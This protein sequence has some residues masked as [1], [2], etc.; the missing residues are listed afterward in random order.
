[1]REKKKRNAA[2]LTKWEKGNG[3]RIELRLILF[4]RVFMKAEFTHT[5]GKTHEPTKV[6][7]VNYSW[8]FS[9][10]LLNYDPI[11]YWEYIFTATFWESYVFYYFIYLVCISWFNCNLTFITFSLGSL[12]FSVYPKVRHFSST[13]IKTSSWFCI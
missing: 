2:E 6:V 11:T 12:S 10:N 8:K 4:E 3:E 5:Y 1:M 9:F 13:T 7:Q